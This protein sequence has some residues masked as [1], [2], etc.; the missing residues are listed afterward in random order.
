MKPCKKRKE[1]KYCFITYLNL[2]QTSKLKENI[3]DN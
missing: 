3:Y 2:K 1:K